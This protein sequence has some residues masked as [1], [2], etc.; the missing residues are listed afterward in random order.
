MFSGLAGKPCLQT[1]QMLVRNLLEAHAAVALA[2]APDHAAHGAKRKTCLRQIK[3]QANSLANGQADGG[4][5]ACTCTAH[6]PQERGRQFFF[7]SVVDERGKRRKIRGVAKT[8]GRRS[9]RAS[10]V[11]VFKRL[12]H[13]QDIGG[14]F[15]GLSTFLSHR[16]AGAHPTAA[17][18]TAVKPEAHFRPILN[19]SF[20]MSF[21]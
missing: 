21:L 4:K 2:V 20:F 10:D 19:H 9:R 5:N 6:V 18:L 8:F 11:V 12:S 3:L 7:F 14:T 16:R 1:A 17:R 15:V 13:I